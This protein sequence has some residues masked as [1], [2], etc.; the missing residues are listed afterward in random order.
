[1]SPRTHID[2]IRQRYP[3]AITT[4]EAVDRFLDLA[5]R[6]LGLAPKQN[7]SAD[8]ICSDDLNSI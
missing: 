2:V 8:S 4:N 7:A 1:M 5:Q 6:R 3:D